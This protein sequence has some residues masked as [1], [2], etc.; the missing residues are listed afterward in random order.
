MSALAEIVRKPG[1]TVIDVRTPVEFQMGHVQGALNIPLE[2]MA[3]RAKEVAA[4]PAPRVLYCRSGNRSG[5]AVQMLSQ[6]GIG[7]LHNGGG[8]YDMEYLLA[9]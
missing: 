1:V 2:E 7:D 9:N 8:L 5:I 3:F 6:A 4:L